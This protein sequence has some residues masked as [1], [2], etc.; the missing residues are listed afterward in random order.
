MAVTH[1]E[2]PGLKYL[3]PYFNGRM[4]ARHADDGSSIL[5]GRTGEGPGSR[6]GRHYLGGVATNSRSSCILVM[7]VLTVSVTG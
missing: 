7:G 3:R 1:L 4:S 5:P 2:D 6:P